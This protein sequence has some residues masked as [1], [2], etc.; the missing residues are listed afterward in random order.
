MAD[1]DKDNGVQEPDF[2]NM[3]DEDMANF[4]ASSMASAPAEV[5]T[6]PVDPAG[7]PVGDDANTDPAPAGEDKGAADQAA[8]KETTNEDQGE[9]G[10]EEDPANGAEAPSGDAEKDGAGK[11]GDAADPAKAD[12]AK[13]VESV[14]DYKAEYEKLM[15]PFKANGRDMQADSIEDARTLMQMGANYNKKMAALKPN[16]RLMKMLDNAGLLDEQKLSFLIDVHAKKPEAISK[17][18]QDSGV[19]P[20]DI[21]AEKAGEYKPSSY[22]VD[23]RTMELEAVLDDL[24]ESSPV[25]R[26]TLEVVSTKWDATSKEIISKEPEILRVIDGHIQSGIYDLI[27]AEV[28][29]ERTFGR[30]KNV[31]ELEAYKATGDAMN[32]Q[33]RFNHL[34]SPKPAVVTPPAA[35]AVVEPKPKQVSDEALNQKRRAASSTKATAPS[36]ALPAD[37]NP[38]DL[39]DEEFAKFKPR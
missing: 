21:S 9:G 26:R 19:D 27:V 29:K 12:P 23:D 16:L 13:P 32:A 3:S 5:V 28:E 30:L 25:Y 15:A 4:D 1:Q 39:P 38:L 8:T 22:T 33:G 24:Q 35:P 14:I 2:L 17:L 10:K 31:S 6:D 20:L 7:D 18:V 36:P 34:V 11:E 37:F